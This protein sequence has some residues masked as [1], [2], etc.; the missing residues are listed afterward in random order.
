M[1]SSSS[2]AS[3]APNAAPVAH[4]ILDDYLREEGRQAA[5]AAADARRDAPRLQDPFARGAA[6]RE[7]D[8]S[9]M[10]ERRLFFH[11]DWLLLGAVL[12]LSGDRRG[13]DLQH[14]LRDAADRRPPGASGRD[15]G[16][17]AVIGLVA[18]LVCLTIDYRLLA[19]YSLFLH[20]GA[21]PAAA[22]RAVQGLDPDGRRSAGFRSARSTCS[23]L[24]SAA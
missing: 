3:T 10:F 15:A 14:H 18:L 24:S 12:L 6:A 2:T 5:A 8:T 23:P 17:R 21:A 22:L 9:D 16:L 4:H 20:G 7:A 13:D 19:E 1:S 11:V